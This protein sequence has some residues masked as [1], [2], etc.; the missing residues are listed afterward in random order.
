MTKRETLGLTKRKRLGV[1]KRKTLGL[2]R[3]GRFGIMG[4]RDSSRLESPHEIAARAD[5][6]RSHHR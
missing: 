5:T 3:T 6:V 1:T 4:E 2:A